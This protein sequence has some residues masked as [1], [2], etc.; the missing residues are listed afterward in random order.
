M[1]YLIL[2]LVVSIASCIQI[3][4]VDFVVVKENTI[5]DISLP[6]QKPDLESD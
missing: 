1:K 2:L 5:E 3:T 4:T 6:G